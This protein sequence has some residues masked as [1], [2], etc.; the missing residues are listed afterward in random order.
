MESNLA[1][2]NLIELTIITRVEGVGA[3]IIEAAIIR[4]TFM[5]G[6]SSTTLVEC[7]SIT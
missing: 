6:G 4:T 5:T 3:I 1:E 2:L 7:V